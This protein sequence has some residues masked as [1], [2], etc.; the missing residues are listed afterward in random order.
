MFKKNKLLFVVIS[1]VILAGLITSSIITGTLTIPELSG[2]EVSEHYI[3]NNG[4]NIFLLITNATD[5]DGTLLSGT[6]KLSIESDIEGEKF[7]C[8]VIFN[9]G[10]AYS[11]ISL[12][13]TGTH[14][15]TFIIDGI[16]EPV[17][18]TVK[19]EESSTAYYG[20]SIGNNPYKDID[21][22]SIN[23][24]KANFH[25]HTSESDGVHGPAYVIDKY[26]EA[27]YKILALT[28]HDTQGRG[29]TKPAN[30]ET[31]WPWT[32]WGRDPA[33]LGMLAVEG[34]EIS[35]PHHHLSLFNGWGAESTSIENSLWQIADMDGLAILSHTGRYTAQYNE[36]SYQPYSTP[37][38]DEWYINLYNK[39]HNAPL[40]GIEIYSLGDSY[41]DDRSL[42]DRLNAILMPNITVFGYSVDDMHHESQMFGN[43]Q[44]M[45]ME[46]LTAAALR[47]AMLA[48]AFYFCYEPEG[49]GA[50]QVPL[51][52]KIEVTDDETVITIAASNIDINQE[53]DS[54][55]WITNKGAV[56][57]GYSFDLKELSLTENA[58]FIRAELVNAYGR[59][60]TQPFVLNH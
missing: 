33:A 15:L 40:V 57:E 44:F 50:H 2:F 11:Y 31:T 60:Y 52:N 30:I 14:E 21:W 58:I 3:Q 42:W 4:A 39:Y 54:I 43:Y 56:G 10:R 49:S 5:I 26:Y 12:Y 24:Y 29:G 36:F 55:T 25:T 53:T 18:L 51:I 34:N 47:E 22:D 32:D 7:S 16:K 28:D 23:H 20:P 8:P 13:S 19:V 1:I 59:T 17:V 37:L 27:G 9:A 46:D 6:Y 45:L 48:G 41:P 38:K 35:A